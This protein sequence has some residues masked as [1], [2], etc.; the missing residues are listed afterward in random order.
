MEE[1]NWQKIYDNVPFLRGEKGGEKRRLKIKKKGCRQNEKIEEQCK[2]M[3]RRKLKGKR[4]LQCS[5]RKP[6]E[7]KVEISSMLLMRKIVDCSG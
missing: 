7:R 3:E 4:G 5:K 1:K 6:E 2:R